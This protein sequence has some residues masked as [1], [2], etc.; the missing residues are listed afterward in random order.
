MARRQKCAGIGLS[1]CFS[2]RRYAGSFGLNSC[3]WALTAADNVVDVD[4]C[5]K[6][7]PGNT[8]LN[9]AQQIAA[10]VR[11]PA[12]RHQITLHRKRFR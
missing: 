1:I 7:P 8:G 5:A 11:S 12:G 4:A 3:Q 2:N 10:K 9:I 6:V